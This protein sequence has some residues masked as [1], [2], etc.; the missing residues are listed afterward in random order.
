MAKERQSISFFDQSEGVE[1]LNYSS[2]ASCKTF[3]GHIYFGGIGGLT[4]LDPSKVEINTRPP[5]ILITDISVQE[6]PV[7]TVRHPSDIRQLEIDYMSNSFSISY[8]GFSYLKP[9][10][11]RYAY[12]LEGYDNDWRHVGGER[13]ARYSGLDAGEYL[14]KVK[15]VNEDGIWSEETSLKIVIPVPYWQKW[16]FYVVCIICFSLIIFLVV[17]WR[18]RKLQREK[19][20]LETR[21]FNATQDLRDKNAEIER[22]HEAL[23]E[24]HREITDSI[25]YA[26]RIQH[27]ILPPDSIVDQYLKE[28]FIL[29]KPKDVVAGDFY[30]LEHY[31]EIIL[32][33]AADCTGH[34]VPGAMV[35]VVCNNALNRAVREYELTEPADILTKVREI[36][37][38]EFDQG[39]EDVKDGM[40]ISLCALNPKTNEMHWAGANNPLWIIRKDGT[41]VEEIKADKMP[42]GKYAK[43]DPFTPHKLQLNIGDSI[44]IFT[45]GYPDQFGGDNGK[46]FKSGNLKK[47]F[48]KIVNQPIKKQKELLNT[49]FESWRGEMEQIDDVCVI[50]VRV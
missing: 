33:A 15:A 6:E 16:W 42:I 25:A 26:K 24:S 17:K 3:A 27:A 11:T 13:T 45:D 7:N 30:W 29:Y 36:V 39:E 38:E 22:Q 1:I 44:Y 20:I 12:M 48:L 9:E 32:F 35:S 34:G 28:N 14:F 47:L 37:I 18:L 5:K 23:E 31:E 10:K 19:K 2:G 49:Q 50:G 46:K 8:I 43:E 40:D 41:E 4:S 21:I